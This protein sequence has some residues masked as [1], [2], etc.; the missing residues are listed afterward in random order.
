MPL[1]KDTISIDLAQGVNNKVDDKIAGPEQTSV[2]VNSRFDKDKRL[3]KRNG[4]TAQALT[5]Q[6]D[7]SGEKNFTNPIVLSSVSCR[8]KTFAHQNQ[9]CLESNGNLFSQYSGQDSWIFKGTY[10]PISIDANRLATNVT[11]YDSV[12]VSGVVVSCGSQSIYVSEERTGNIIL[13]TDLAKTEFILRP[14]AFSN[15][16]YVLTNS[17]ASNVM[18]ARPVNLSSGIV[19][20]TVTVASDYLGYAYPP[21]LALTSSASAIGEANFITY[22]AV[23]GNAKAVPFLS[24]GSVSSL[25]PYV[26]NS[27]SSDMMSITIEPSTNPNNFYLSGRATAQSVLFNASTYSQSWFQTYQPAGLSGALYVSTAVY[28]AVT[29][30]I[31]PVNDRDLLIFL[32]LY[33]NP[34]LLIPGVGE[35]SNDRMV[36]YIR[37]GSQGAVVSNDVYSRGVSLS[38]NAFRDI[39]RKTVYLPCVYVSPLQTTL[40]LA[41]VL[42]GRER[43]N[44]F[45]GKALYGQA[46]S[47][48]AVPGGVNVFPISQTSSVGTNTFRIINNN[49]LVD[50]NLTPEYAPQSQ[51]YA[52]TTHLTGGFLWSYDGDT[53]AEHNFLISPEEIEI[54]ENPSAFSTVTTQDGAGA[55]PEMF[56]IAP[57]AAIAYGGGQT[58]YVQ[59]NTTTSTAS[60]YMILDGV[61]TSPAIAG[62]NIGVNVTAIDSVYDVC[63][64]IVAA[65]NASGIA[66]TAQ[67]NIPGGFLD[68]VLVTNTS[69]GAVPN[70]SV[71]GTNLGGP[72]AAGS[73]QYAY[74]YAWEDKSGN[75]YRSA[76]S[77]PTTVNQIGT[78]G[79]SIMMWAP[80][81]TNKPISK[82]K[83]ELYRT[84]V[85]GSVFHFIDTSI[86]MSSSSARIAFYDSYSDSSISA[87]RILYTNGDVLENYNIGAV[88]SVSFFKER[89]QVTGLADDRYA[90]Y[91]SKQVLPNEPVNFAAE[92]FYRVDADN[93]PVIATAQM[94]DK[95][96]IFKPNL[97]Y[98]VSGDGANELGEGSTLSPPMLV[99]SDTGTNNPNSI[100]LYPN[101]LLYKSA[102]GIYNLNRSLGVE[103]IG[104]P[105]EDYNQYKVSGAVLMK[106]Q[107]EIRFTH[108]DNSTAIVYNYYFGRWDFFD[109]YKADSASN[110]NGKIIL[111]RDNGKVMVENNYNYDIDSGSQSYSMYLET[112]WLKLKGIQDFQRI[113]E[114][115]FLGEYLSQ[116]TFTVNVQYNYNTAD[117]TSY[118]FDA[119]TIVT[120]TYTPGDGV[121]QFQTS[122]DQQ[123]CESIKVRLTENPNT[124]SSN[125]SSLYLNNM[126]AVVGL[127]RGLNKLPPNKM[128]SS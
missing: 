102:K 48:K 70:A 17:S 84:L 34:D 89:L 108:Q 49:Y 99:A 11:F 50:F 54:Q 41:D 5:F 75:I 15:A 128:I 53:I 37:L 64:K 7:F 63:Y 3:Q 51:F 76:P 23:V 96:I 126:S 13:K 4:I 106:N 68:Q 28:Q 58:R 117:S 74:C 114:L 14:M 90:I 10:V 29:S 118:I 2:L 24:V 113:Y 91:Y 119:A 103:Y 95:S 39:V 82:V 31:S 65:I 104:A 8:T 81:L 19:G 30:V 73:Y 9:L 55:T 85:N 62:T 101:G 21:N 115:D 47:F 44:Y 79:A 120:P 27:V 52:N 43:Y 12:T 92:L 57:V 38:G 36:S 40:L 125:Q 105:V 109:N 80:A 94:D 78:S 18:S 66:A 123:K 25:G 111:S 71:A 87:N 60:I 98:A 124:T 42:E 88:K 45:V 107:T 6:G 86:N 33:T 32:G 67:I 127:K 20:S 93:D 83:V 16:A 22:A 35:Y 112:P 97:V 121:Y 61:G 46:R 26:I 56:T 72:L 1:E 59:F 77:I 100:V 69:N 122:L 116:H 110:W